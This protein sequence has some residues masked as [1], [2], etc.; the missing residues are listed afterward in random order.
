MYIYGD[1][2]VCYSERCQVGA[3]LGVWILV[4]FSVTTP[5]DQDHA[6]SV[7]VIIPEDHHTNLHHCIDLKYFIYL[8]LEI[9]V[10]GIYLI[11][12]C[13]TLGKLFPLPSVHLPSYEKPPLSLHMYMN[14]VL[15][16]GNFSQ[17]TQG[18]QKIPYARPKLWDLLGTIPGLPTRRDMEAHLWPDREVSMAPKY[19]VTTAAT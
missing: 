6:S 9:G 18:T 11:P 12:E 4:V 19:A 3:D 15:N 7:S 14:V 16:R 1:N 10:D 13:F 2:V 5:C 8:G 17:Y